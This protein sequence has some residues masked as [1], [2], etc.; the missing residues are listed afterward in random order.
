[1]KGRKKVEPIIRFHRLRKKQR[2][3]ER[4][5]SRPNRGSAPPT[6][7]SDETVQYPSKSSLLSGKIGRGEIEKI[8]KG[9]PLT[10]NIINVLLALL[11][12]VAIQQSCNKFY[13]TNVYF[14]K[15]LE[16][17]DYTDAG[18]WIQE[19]LK[20][21]GIAVPVHT[22]DSWNLVGIENL[23]HYSEEQ[24]ADFFFGST[25]TLEERQMRNI[26][27]RLLNF[28]FGKDRRKGKVTFHPFA[29]PTIGLVDSSLWLFELF[30]SLYD[31]DPSTTAGS[32]TTRQGILDNL[33]AIWDKRHTGTLSQLPA[34]IRASRLPVDGAEE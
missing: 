10:Y 14:W 22:D 27:D 2:Q 15:A 9:G 4:L 17:D 28:L 23:Q 33:N 29:P 16:R 18:R 21:D 8:Q 20:L 5:E 19:P 26:C 6:E 34:D 12:E 31:V 24:G 32:L 11:R 30:R 7:E 1:M 3:R 25:I 13:I